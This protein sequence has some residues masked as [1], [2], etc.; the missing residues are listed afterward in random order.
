VSGFPTRKMGRL[1]RD[2]ASKLRP[3]LHFICQNGVGG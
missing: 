3:M 1:G 2:V